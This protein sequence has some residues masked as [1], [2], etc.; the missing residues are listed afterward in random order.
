MKRF[1]WVILALVIFLVKYFVNSPGSE[2]KFKNDC[3]V[4]Y[5]SGATEADA[6]AVGAEL[7]RMGYFGD[8]K[9]DVQLTRDSG[10]FQLRFVVAKSVNL[11][12]AITGDLGLYAARI[13][14]LALNN[15]PVQAVAVNEELKE[16]KAIPVLN[17]GKA[18]V[19]G[20]GV[21]FYT[22]AAGVDAAKKVGEAL[23]KANIGE[24]M[25][26]L[27]KKGDGY[28]VSVPFDNPE[29]A[30]S[31]SEEAFKKIGEMV[32][33]FLAAPVTMQIVTPGFA[34]LKTIS[35]A[36][37][38]APE[39]PVPAAS[40]DAGS[41]QESPSEEEAEASATPSDSDSEGKE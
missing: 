4:Y 16:I 8:R 21:L 38:K 36:P 12:D 5:K 34:P 40:T 39:Q 32:G 18:L 33:T 22:D 17:L 41:A 20:K 11:T 31:A 15:Q 10:T 24:F 35:A 7:E 29:D 13:S 6:K 27:D 9:A 1:F 26:Q 2:V 25:W 14:A 23:T 28:I 37:V 3:A 19:V 30:K